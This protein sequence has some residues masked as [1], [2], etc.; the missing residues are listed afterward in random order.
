VCRS[1][2][3]PPGVRTPAR[4]RPQLVAEREPGCRPA[5][6]DPAPRSPSAGTERERAA[7]GSPTKPDR[8]A[9]ARVDPPR[10]RPHR[11]GPSRAGPGQ[12]SRAG[13][14][15]GRARSPPAI[16]VMPADAEP[17][18]APGLSSTFGAGRQ[19]GRRAPQAVSCLSRFVRD[20]RRVA[21][22]GQPR[23]CWPATGQPVGSVSRRGVQGLR[24]GPIVN[25]V[26]RPG[27]QGWWANARCPTRA[28][29]RHDVIGRVAPRIPPPTIRLWGSRWGHWNRCDRRVSKPGASQALE[30]T[31]TPPG[32][33]KIA[34][35]N[36]RRTIS[37]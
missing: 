30:G 22:A 20:S 37:E 31:S 35:R 15:S 26:R 3:A 28:N 9:T 7:R 16:S 27:R 6:R 19:P 5:P 34:R 14:N 21:S 13:R 11:L 8:G 12:G 1:F 2:P 4:R 25:L 18:G 32:R 10:R 17:V 33:A 29:F 23:R 36:T 24:R